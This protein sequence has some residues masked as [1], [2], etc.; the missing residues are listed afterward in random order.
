[1]RITLVTETY[2]PQVN[3][4]SRTLGQLV[5]ALEAR[6]DEVQVIQ[7]RYPE[8]TG[9]PRSVEVRALSLPF[10]RELYLPLPP[11][12]GPRRALDA[13]RPDIVHIATEAT[14]GLWALRHCRKRRIPVVS[15]FHT[16][17]DQYADHYRVGWLRR[18]IW[19]YL[20]WFHNSTRE[21]YVPS[22]ATR[23]SLTARG[24]ERLV[25]WPRGVDCG[26]F[27][28]DRPG[29]ARVRQ[30]LGLPDDAVVIGHVSRI[31]VEKNVAWL[32]EA[33]AEVQRRRPDR[34]RLLI[35]GDGPARPE[36]EAKLGPAAAFAGYRTGDDL[37][38]HYAA[39]DLFAFASLSET[40]GNVV[41]EAMATGLP[42]VAVR[43]GGPGEIVQDGST[44]YLVEPD[45]PPEAMARRLV[46][47]VDDPA[48]RD[49]M[50]QASRAYAEAQSWSCI[51]DAL[52][53]RY[54]AI[55]G[56]S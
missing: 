25:L 11:F 39:C 54:G 34:V 31:A 52:R 8:P 26:L 49:R 53:A 32:G 36:L 55:L 38:D 27:H 10:Y 7:P 13:F 1:M 28:R 29:R 14:L 19:R 33:L 16:N 48:L 47:L 21:T 24:F 23:D 6:G 56:D 40:F 2:A 20:R 17:F 42:V 30:A 12:G 18:T 50:A 4:V 9:R 41:L 37:C 35:V 3:G 46:D 43:A 5:R 44:G 22:R 45:A 51:M 15:S